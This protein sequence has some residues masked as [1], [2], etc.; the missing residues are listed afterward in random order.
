MKSWKDAGRI[1]TPQASEAFAGQTREIGAYKVE[2]VSD[3]IFHVFRVGVVPV[4]RRPSP[5]KNQEV[6]DC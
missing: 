1:L 3:D 5:W 6:Q 2:K 4:K